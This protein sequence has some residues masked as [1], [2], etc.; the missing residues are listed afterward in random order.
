MRSPVWQFFE[1]HEAVLFMIGSAL[2]IAVTIVVIY[3]LNK[4]LP[5]S[6]HTQHYQPPLEDEE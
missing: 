6:A 3:V 5:A 4:F 1:H 2:L